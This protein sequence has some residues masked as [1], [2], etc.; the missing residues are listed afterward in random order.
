M[1]FTSSG[2][3]TQV[4]FGAQGGADGVYGSQVKGGYTFHVEYSA[5]STGTANIIQY[6]KSSG[7]HAN[8]HRGVAFPVF[9]AGAH[10]YRI[11]VSDGYGYFF[12]DDNADPWVVKLD[13]DYNGGYITLGLND[14][15]HTI[16][17]LKIVD[18]DAKE[19]ELTTV[20][21]QVEDITID[22]AKG[23][24]ITSMP[25]VVL[26]ADS[27]GNEYPVLTNWKN[28]EY[29]S[30]KDGTFD[31]NAEFT[32]LHNMKLASSIAARVRV[33]N[34]INGDFDPDTT[35]KYYF[36]HENDLLDFTAYY[37]EQQEK[38]GF[39]KN[40]KESTDYWTGYE[41]EL[42][43]ANAVTDKWKISDGKLTTGYSYN[44]GGYNGASFA[45]GVS[46]MILNDLNLLNF[47]IQVDFKQGNNFW[48]NA[49][50][51]GVNDPTK[52]IASCYQG[53]N[54]KPGG[55][56]T[57][58]KN[59]KDS[60]AGTL[61]FLEQ[62]GCINFR[63]GVDTGDGMVRFSEDLNGVRFEDY[64]D[65]KVSHHLTIT[66]LNGI[67]MLR[68]DDSKDTYV[69]GLTASSVG[70]LVGLSAYGNL[71][72]FDNFQV[73]AIDGKMNPTP[74]DTAER[75]TA[76]ETDLSYVGWVPRNPGWTFEWGPEYED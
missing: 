55:F 1:D 4:G 17:N 29:R 62:E 54:A 16:D 34:S 31:F 72:S 47:E 12:C 14:S 69:S 68:V 32:G 22:R 46:T 25:K 8:A 45:K 11:A 65:K 66:V 6:V 49:V 28:S 24:G 43:K 52:F 21:T 7:K 39:W 56:D 42:V 26:A 50:A 18:L 75:G 71:G 41:G 19:I 35:I 37:S 9:K 76:Q 13:D 15:S 23:E 20:K 3:W 53:V 27:K 73:T 48:Y 67:V 61:V 64:Y 33:V 74:L 51:I 44:S 30:Y 59:N 2:R 60:G 38:A 70:G 63:G 57:G 10:H 5:G 36:D 40:D 58:V